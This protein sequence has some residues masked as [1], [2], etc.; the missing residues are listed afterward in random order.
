MAGLRLHSCQAQQVGPWVQAP[1]L[2]RGPE[3]TPLCQLLVQPHHL[4]MRCER[5][6]HLAPAVQQGAYPESCSAMGF[7]QALRAH[8]FCSKISC[9]LGQHS[10][11]LSS[12]HTT[13]TYMCA[14]SLGFLNSFLIWLKSCSDTCQLSFEL[15]MEERFVILY[16]ADNRIEFKTQLNLNILLAN[17]FFKLPWELK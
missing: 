16:S 12:P 7:P 4:C 13:Y 14:L 8:F 15:L 11:A 1:Q 3:A 2:L 9:A 10:V 5:T 6:S 17:L